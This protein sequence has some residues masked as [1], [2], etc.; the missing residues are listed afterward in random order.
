VSDGDLFSD[1]SSTTATV[2]ALP[3]PSPPPPPPPDPNLAPTAD[4]GG[5]YTGT[6]NTLITFDGSASFDPDD[7]DDLTYAWDFGDGTVLSGIGAIVSHAYTLFGTYSV[8]L[9][10]RDA[11]GLTD[12]DSQ[13]VEVTSTASIDSIEITKA[14]YKL[15]NGE[16]K[17]EATSTMSDEAVLTVV[18]YGLMKHRGRDR[19][20][21][22]IRDLENSVGTVTVRSSLG[23][24]ATSVVVQ[25]GSEEDEKKKKKEKKEKKE[26]DEDEDDDEEEDDD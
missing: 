3:P 11:A 19:F 9:T 24:E 18:G 20:K 22:R 10:V 5:P 14:E 8:T 23:G 16:L 2:E 21:L 1:P 12:Q 15:R 25:S 4:V 13:T 26:K 7:D 6:E 17:V